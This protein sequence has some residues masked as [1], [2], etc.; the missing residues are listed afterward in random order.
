L[1]LNVGL[2][3][4]LA[5]VLS[6]TQE[7]N[8]GA[9]AAPIAAESGQQQPPLPIDQRPSRP[10]SPAVETEPFNWSQMESSD[11]RTYIANLRRVGCPEQTIRDIITADLDGLY[12]PKREVL[13]R[14]LAVADSTAGLSG[15]RGI[16]N[17][18][19]SLRDEE[20]A[21]LA[22]LLGAER[23][24]GQMAAEATPVS[25]SGPARTAE[26]AASLPLVFQD[27]DIA[28]LKLNDRRVQ[29]MDDLKQ[30][31]MDEIGGPAQDPNDP[32]YRARWLNAQPEIDN[33]TR[34]MIGVNAFQDYQLAARARQQQG[35]PGD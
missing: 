15:R 30:R 18:L 27:A 33:M 22:A 29:A 6:R 3:G 10:A 23:S 13:Q 24:P 35:A 25:A 26:T 5:W 4:C 20:A 11:Y 14:K 16:E 9:P 19:D 7:A 2:I 34:G 31:F 1:L 32:G 17:A 8:I 21:T 12:S 28:A